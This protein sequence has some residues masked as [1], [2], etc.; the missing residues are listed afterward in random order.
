MNAI[1]HD[2]EIPISVFKPDLV[3]LVEI[4]DRKSGSGLVTTGSVESLTRALLSCFSLK[5]TA[6][7]LRIFRIVAMA[8]GAVLCGVLVL[9]GMSFGMIS[10]AVA[11]YQLVWLIPV[12]IVSNI[13][14]K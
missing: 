14:I 12:I 13:N 11:L 2:S 1:R 7:V 10:A 3:E 8:I 5:K 9:T 4:E 6:N